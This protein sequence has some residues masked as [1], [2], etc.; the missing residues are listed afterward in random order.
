MNKEMQKVLL[1]LNKEEYKEFQI[2]SL[3]LNKSVSERI[4]EFIKKEIEKEK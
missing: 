1:L 2:Q 4:R 3:I